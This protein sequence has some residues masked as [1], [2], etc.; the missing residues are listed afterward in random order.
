MEQRNVQNGNQF[1]HASQ[2][3]LRIDHACYKRNEQ[4]KCQSLQN[5]NSSSCIIC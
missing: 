4:V 5:H 2:I 3:L 1:K